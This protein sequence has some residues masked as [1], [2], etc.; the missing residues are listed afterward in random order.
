MFLSNKTHILYRIIIKDY[1]EHY[2]TIHYAHSPAY[3]VILDSYLNGV[4]I[5]VVRMC[6]GSNFNK[7]SMPKMM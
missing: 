2:I 5:F 6:R 1:I 3:L 4:V 7:H